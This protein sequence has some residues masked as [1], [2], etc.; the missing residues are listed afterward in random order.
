MRKIFIAIVATTISAMAAIAQEIKSPTVKSATSFAIVVDKASYANAKAAVDA[1]RQCVEEDGLGSYLAIADWQ[2]PEQIRQLLQEWHA[3]RKQPLEG[4]VFVGDIPIPM[5]RDAQYLTSAFKMSQKRDW[6]ESSVPTDRFYDDFSLKFDFLK[7]DADRKDYFYYSLSPDGAQTLSPDIYSARIRPPHRAGQD[8]YQVLA[9]YLE[10]VVR[11]RKAEA[12]KNVLDRLTMARGHGYNSED[13]NVWSGEQLALREQM[14]QLFLPG[15]SAKFFSFEMVYPARKLYLN[16]VQDDRLDVMLFHHHG[17]PDTQYLNGY[18]D[19]NTVAPSLDNVKRFLRSKVLRA[20]R[21]APRDSAVAEYAQRYGVPEAWCREAFDS[22]LAVKDSI[23]NAEMDIHVEDILAIKPSARFV[24]FDACF[25]GSFY[26]DDC[27]ANAYI[28]NHGNTI[29]TMGNTVN[30][31]QDKWP[32]EF[33]GLLASGMR[34]GQFNRFTC[35]LET[36][37]IGDPT[38]RFAPN[39]GIGFDINRALTLQQGDQKFWKKQLSSPIA[40]VQAMALRQLF[41]AHC[42]DMPQLLLDTYFNS[43]QFVVRMEALKLLALNYPEESV[44]ALSAALDDGYELIRRLSLAYV[45]ENGN[46]DLLP[47]LVSGYL[48][49]WQESRYSFKVLDALI[50]FNPDNI[51]E[52]VKRQTKGLPTYD[53]AFVGKLDYQARRWAEDYE[54]SHK[55]MFD[56]SIKP[57]KRLSNILKMRNYPNGRLIPDLIALVAD[58]TESSEIRSTAANVLGWFT[59]WH[60]RADIVGKLSSII[61]DDPNINIELK[62]AVKRLSGQ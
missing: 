33:V 9:Q 14:P 51:S 17:A 21:K 18:P 43:P 10:K 31:I 48:N 22:A 44:K 61:T 58:E 42:A 47:A 4:C 1:Y 41:L 46:P 53:N 45:E 2:D 28:F 25:N 52:E 50:A 62:R 5:V 38:Y 8:R 34:V 3:D 59:S 40:D 19:V 32:D 26:E 29:A 57:A 56:R 37:L 35:Y 12:G 60:G 15:A 6:K 55:M 16:E 30:T 7:R 13:A 27:I 39:S 49:R 23:F 11:V 54:E 36:H 24:L 20:A